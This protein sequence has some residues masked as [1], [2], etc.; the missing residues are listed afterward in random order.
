L[1]VRMQAKDSKKPGLEAGLCPG[2][3]ISRAI[4]ADIIALIR[5]KTDANGAFGGGIKK[6]LLRNMPSN[7]LYNSIYAPFPFYTPK[8]ISSALQALGWDSQYLLNRPIKTLRVISINS[9]AG[10]IAVLKD[11][12]TFNI[13]YG[14][15]MHMLTN[16]YGMP[17][18]H[19]LLIGI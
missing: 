16:G 9:W 4:L 15:A 12:R 17:L 2:Y 14:D 6:L 7:Y 1:Y 11:Y 13:E 19:I 3:T 8:T 5:D 18:W 10:V